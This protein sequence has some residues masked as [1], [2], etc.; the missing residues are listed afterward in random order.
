MIVARPSTETDAPLKR[1]LGV[2]V[3]LGAIL[4]LL[5]LAVAA[6]VARRIAR[7]VAALAMA[8]RELADWKPIAAPSGAMPTEIDR[9]WHDLM[10]A[11]GKLL[12]ATR[13]AQHADARHRSVIDTAMDAIV[14]TD[15][16]GRI[17][18]FNKAASG[19]WRRALR[20][21]A[22]LLLCRIR[23]ALPPPRD[24][25]DPPIRPA[26]IHGFKPGMKPDAILLRTL[27]VP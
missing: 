2:A 15:L 8:G 3:A 24:H 22:R 17:A 19:S 9:L 16:E 25:L 4:L 5:S 26:F 27:R 12:A 21:D 6:A 1:T 13:A 14:V 18:L 23:A 10:G 20:H 11:S 7:P